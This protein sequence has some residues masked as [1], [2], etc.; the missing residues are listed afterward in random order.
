[1]NSVGAALDE[2]ITCAMTGDQQ[3]DADELSS[4]GLST[5]RTMFSSDRPPGGDQDL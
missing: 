1:V 2:P 4:A 5:N 3:G